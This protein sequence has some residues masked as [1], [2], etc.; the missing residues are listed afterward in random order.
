MAVTGA[1]I[2][3][4]L[5]DLLEDIPLGI[6]NIPHEAIRAYGISMEDLQSESFRL[7]VR[8]QTE[9][10]RQAFQAGKDYI[11][12]INILRCKLAGVW[13]LARFECILNAIERDGYRLRREYPER[14]CPAAWVE[15]VRLGIV[16]TGAHI[17]R[18]IRRALPGMQRQSAL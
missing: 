1:H 14:H 9:S 10:A 7:W 3:H 11:E 15:M 5:R 12:S 6:I 4:M 17:S 18:R 8:E 2:T 13:Y 16:V